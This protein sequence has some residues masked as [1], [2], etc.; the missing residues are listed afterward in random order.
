VGWLGLD[1]TDS[2][3]GGCTTEVFHRLL[4]SL[5]P[6]TRLGTPRLV[7]LW[8]FAQRRTRGN[9][10]L[11]IELNHPRPEELLA[12]LDEWWQTHI[13]PLEG[14]V[15]TSKRSDRDQSPA[16][17]GMVWF[18]HQPKPDVYWH[19]VRQEVR[20]DELPMATRSWGGH[21]RI[22]ATAA[23]AWPALSCTWEA[24]SWRMDE[25][26]GPRQLNT[27]MLEHLD[28]WPDIVL[29]RDPRK[30]KQLVAPRGESPL[31]FG[32]RSLNRKDAERACT[33]LLEAEGTESAKG[34]RIFQT[35]Q[36]TGDHLEG[37]LQAQVLAVDVD[38]VRKHVQ[39]ETDVC[40]M[41]LYAEGGP[42][43]ALGRWLAVGDRIEVR[44]LVHPSGSLHVEQVR[45]VQA[46]PRKTQ[47]PL[48]VRCQTRM[49]SMGAGQGIR[50]PACKHRSEDAWDDVEPVPPFVGWLEPPMDARRHL[51]RPLSWL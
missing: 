28:Q 43:N 20:I 2:L 41:V 25:Q 18:E 12:H 17:P 30:G 10:A 50:C 19:A 16:S 51:A 26:V 4:N 49:K 48:C 15:L 3:A 39:L 35:N 14:A 11:S 38:A 44:G 21:G 32:L 45:L 8:P 31:L 47:R 29:S 23:A 36:A 1:D 24:I 9:A 7:R 22:G 34:W 13:A 33:L 42:V 27:Q 5:P 46:V 37:T 40:P 6:E